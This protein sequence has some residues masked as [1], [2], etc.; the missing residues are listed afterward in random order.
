MHTCIIIIIQKYYNSYANRGS[1]HY[2]TR[3]LWSN[4]TIM[5]VQ[6]IKCG[7]LATMIITGITVTS[8]S[9]VTTSNRAIPIPIANM[10]YFFASLAE[11]WARAY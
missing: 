10:L 11:A 9:R 4:H 6:F 1:L 8:V 7:L 2:Y 5:L 3:Q